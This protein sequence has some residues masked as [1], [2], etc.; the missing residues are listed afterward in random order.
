MNESKSFPEIIKNVKTWMSEYNPSVLYKWIIVIS[1]HPSNQ[2][3]QIRFEFLL[4]IL[5]SMNTEQFKNKKLDYQALNRSISK[6]KKETDSIFYRVEDFTPLSQLKLIPY[7]FEKNKYYFFYGQLER[8]YESI[9]ILEKIYICEIEEHPELILIKNLF[10]QILIFQTRILDK[11]VRIEESKETLKNGIYIPTLDF[12]GEFKDLLTINDDQVLDS[13][14]ILKYSEQ[15]KDPTENFEEILYGGYFNKIYLDV[16]NSESVI[17]L[18]H[19]QIEVLFKIFEKIIKS[20]ENKESIQRIIQINLTNNLKDLFISFF[21]RRDLMDVIVNNRGGLISKDSNL[22]VLFENNL[23]LFSIVDLFSDKELSTQLTES[24]EE[25]KRVEQDILDERII[26]LKF[27]NRYYYEAPVNEIKIIKII[28]YESIDLSPKP[29][30]FSFETNSKMTVISIMDLISIF[31]LTSSPLKFI[32][33][34]EEKYNSSKF[35]T[36]DQIDIFAAFYNNNESLPSFGTDIITL[37]PHMWSDFYNNYL[38]N[39]FSDSIYELIEQD[40]P[41]KF[42]DVKK[43]MDSQDLYECIDKRDLFS[44]NIIKLEGRLIWIFNPYTDPILTLEDYEVAM[45][46]I[47]PLYADYIQRMLN[48]FKN[49]I[50]KYTP[51]EKYNI[52]LIPKKICNG[53][54]FLSQFKKDYDKVNEENPIVVKSFVNTHSILISNVF[55]NHEFWGEKFADSKNNENALYAIRQ[56]IYSLIRHFEPFLLEEETYNKIDDFLKTHFISTERDY[57]LDAIPTR[58]SSIKK[59]TSY[60]KLNPTD[61]ERVIK[62]VESYLREKNFI[63]RHLSP[64]ESKDLFNEIYKTFYEKLKEVLSQF[65]ISVLYY[66]YKQLELIEGK[67]YLIKLEAGMKI[68]TQIDESYQDY[69]KKKYDEISKLSSIHRFIIHNILKFGINGNQ[70]INAIDYSYFQALSLYLISISQISDFTFSK[71]IEYTINIKDYYK[72]D[73]VRSSSIFDYDAFKEVESKSKLEATKDFYNRILSESKK[74]I[75]NFII[76]EKE[77]IMIKNL[78]EAFQSQLAFSFTNMMRV[79]SIL[80]SS[81]QISDDIMMFP[82][83]LIQKEDLVQLI[84]EEYMKEFKECPS[85]LGDSI[86]EIN[87][88]EV[89]TIL[90]YLSLDFHSFE[91]EEILLHLKIMKQKN[92]LTLCPLIEINNQIIFGKQCCNVAFQIWRR[93]IFAGIFP[94]K[95]PE[96]DKI[97]IA[98]QELHSYQDIIFEDECGDIAN[99]ALGEKNYIIRLK[100]FNR[101]SSQLPKYPDC[102]EIDLLAV[103]LQTKTCFILDAKN[104]YLKLNPYDIKNEINRFIRN[105]KSDLKKLHKKEKFVRDNLNLFL[106]YFEI[107]DQQNWKFKKGFVIKFNFPSAYMKDIDADF[108]F[109]SDLG[110]YLKN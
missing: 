19:I 72:F 31:E 51:F 102:G 7:F 54:P 2:K 57:Y 13:R 18:P 105:N 8:M 85:F 1:I 42:N 45:R 103:N 49:L 52:F 60:L 108:I 26:H 75:Q 56:L 47:G 10:K 99:E 61:Q 39:K 98:L 70:K 65:D 81:N 22:I 90:K 74:D 14:F 68:P 16:S 91:G 5:V 6:F 93:N 12:F 94:Y 50:N 64:E 38:L 63:Q 73:E 84:Q 101:I 29:I 58:N 35:L 9:R 83:V 104:Y 71:L 80:S 53:K 48:P 34:L 46:V 78:E 33:F 55:Y 30:L 106:D 86:K 25:L 36:S 87:E 37:A 28:L 62:E 92:R 43:W 77:K 44:A 15:K 67:R 69:F 82:S 79:L 107:E 110:E 96:S 21:N 95:I 17:I 66:A 88:T 3:F 89:V 23:I 24:Y 4:A 32:K 97:S 76:P 40:F 109:Q 100:K 27:A 20:S 11:I 59:Y 41:N